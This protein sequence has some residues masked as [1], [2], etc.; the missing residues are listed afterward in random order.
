MSDKIITFENHENVSSPAQP[1]IVGSPFLLFLCEQDP[2]FLIEK[3][4]G[5]AV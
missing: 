5:Q 3:D 2:A 4:C 1:I